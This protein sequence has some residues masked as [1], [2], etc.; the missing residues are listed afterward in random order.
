MRWQT[1][2]SLVEFGSSRVPPLPIIIKQS[3]TFYSLVIIDT[4]VIMMLSP[5]IFI[6]YFIFNESPLEY[7][8]QILAAIYKKI[9]C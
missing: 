5:F 7:R 9:L 1:Y 8:K 4:Q 3:S 6:Y 2:K